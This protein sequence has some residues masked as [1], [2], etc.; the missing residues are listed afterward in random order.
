MCLQD[1]QPWPDWG[2]TD[3]DG[4]SPCSCTPNKV[5]RCCSFG[6]TQRRVGLTDR[7]RSA[8]ALRVGG[9]A[10]AAYKTKCE[11]H[12]RGLRVPTPGREASALGLCISRLWGKSL[13]FPPS[14]SSPP[15][16]FAL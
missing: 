3:P 10:R 2:E 12:Q 1:A 11:K 14:P 8:M 15:T 4:G 5:S 16:T 6:V 9:S 13:P 7:V